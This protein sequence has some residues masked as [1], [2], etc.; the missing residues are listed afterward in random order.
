[1]R[2][3]AVLTWPEGNN[4]LARKLKASYE[5]KIRTNSLVYSIEPIESGVHIDYF[6]PITNSSKRIKAKKCIVC[7]PQFVNK[8]II[9]NR[10]VKYENAYDQFSYSPWMIANLTMKPLDERNGRPLSWD[11]VFYNSESLGYVNATHQLPQQV[12]GARNLTYYLPLTGGD[13]KAERVKAASLT[14][15]DWCKLVIADMEKVHPGIEPLIAEIN[16]TLW[17]HSMVQP[18]P[19]FLF[20]EPRKELAQ[21][22]DNSIHFAHTDI[23]GISIFEEA[24]YQGI[25]AAEKVIENL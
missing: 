19:G 7:T 24:F 1:M 14:H 18:L 3:P 10:A 16:V 25:N 15:E 2:E 5:G 4:F 22:I 11:N 21:S 13:S 9:K 23:A 8:R 6:D 20:G 12:F 17:G